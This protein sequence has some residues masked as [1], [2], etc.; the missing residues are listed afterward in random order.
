MIEEHRLKEYGDVVIHATKK[1]T[2]A[3]KLKRDSKTIACAYLRQDG[4]YYHLY[5]VFVEEELR[6]KGYGKRVMDA[7]IE[8]FGDLDLKLS[9]YPNRIS[10]MTP[11]NKEEYRA[12]L[13][14][15]YEKFGFVKDTRSNNMF[16]I[17]DTHEDI[18][19]LFE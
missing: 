17:H 6:G 14:K 2:Y 9:A 18:T 8:N 11:E 5:R 16:R 15:F 13:F 1:G 4:Q 19:E 7:V 10:A 12:K 3:I